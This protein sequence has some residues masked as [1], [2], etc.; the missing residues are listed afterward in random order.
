MRNSTV[1]FLAS[2]S[3][4]F[5][6]VA[7]A[8]AAIVTW[9][10]QGSVGIGSAAALRVLCPP[11]TGVA[12]GGG[13]DPNNVLFMRVTSSAPAFGDANEDRLILQPNGPGGAPV[14]WQASTRNED[15]IS[16]TFNVGVI[17]ATDVSVSTMVGSAFVDPAEQVGLRVFCPEGSA[18][19]GGGVDTGNILFVTV[20]S[21]GPIFGGAPGST[22]S[23]IPLGSAAAPSGWEA[24]VRNDGG[25]AQNFKVAAIC[26]SELSVTTVVGAFPLP[27][28]GFGATRLQCP[29]G[30]IA[31]G[32]GMRPT[33]PATAHETADAPAFGTEQ[34]DRL[35]TQPIGANE[36][37]VAW[38]GALANEVA[39]VGSARLGVVCV[40]EPGALPLALAAFA[41]LAA[42]RRRV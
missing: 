4:A 9:V 1:S 28:M 38:Q 15:S 36:A 17:C 8:H 18:A 42:L 21:Q 24:T 12:I 25:A 31:S 39:P 16:H 14:A 23:Q 7:S 33:D 37:P 11:G 29:D 32:G 10:D 2:A 13:L 6:A 19:V 3:I 20:N 40:P 35:Y 5:A 26:S 30:L 41:S 27:A 22:L 34:F